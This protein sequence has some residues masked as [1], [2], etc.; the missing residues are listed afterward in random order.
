MHRIAGVPRFDYHAFLWK[1]AK[2]QNDSA[3]NNYKST[4]KKDTD[5]IKNWHK[6]FYFNFQRQTPG[7]YHG[8]LSNYHEVMTSNQKRSKNIMQALK[9]VWLFHWVNY[10]CLC[11]TIY[12]QFPVMKQCAKKISATKH[13]N[14]CCG[15]YN[16][17]WQIICKTSDKTLIE[18]HVFAAIKR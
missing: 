7:C 16:L 11:C 2:Q 5:G 4:E 15:E 9:K 17:V 12:S 3:T 8:Y 13:S 18:I 1:T 6:N 10:Q 14:N